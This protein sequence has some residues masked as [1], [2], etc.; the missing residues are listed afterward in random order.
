MKKICLVLLAL[1]TI[2]TFAQTREDTTDRRF[3]DDL[4]DNLAGKWNLTAVAHG[5]PFTCVLNADWVLNHQ[6]LHIYLKSNEV[7]P[8]IDVPM[9]FEYFI[10]YSKSNKRYVVQEMSV[11][12]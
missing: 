9:E 8:W 11:F 5:S 1:F 7:V 4:L 10:G 3:H 12:G 2:Q 6:H